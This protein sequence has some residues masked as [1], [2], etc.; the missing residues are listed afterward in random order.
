MDGG[1]DTPD[2]LPER[3]REVVDELDASELPALDQHVGELLADEGPS[4]TAD[5]AV[6]NTESDPRTERPGSETTQSGSRNDQPDRP[7]WLAEAPEGVPGK[8]TA[9]IKAIN[10]NRHHYWQW[11]AGES[12][13]IEARRASRMS[14]NWRRFTTGL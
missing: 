13:K 2:E 10:G 8:A 7:E 12:V 9:V 6:G 1:S 4:T 5:R 11:R 3:V 14:G